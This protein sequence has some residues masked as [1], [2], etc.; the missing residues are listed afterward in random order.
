[1]LLHPW[2]AAP[3][4]ASAATGLAPGAVFGGRHLLRLLYTLPCLLPP[5]RAADGGPP[6]EAQLQH[7][8]RWLH[9]RRAWALDGGPDPK[10]EVDADADADG[11]RGATP[12]ASG[13]RGASETPAASDGGGGGVK[14][15]PAP[16]PPAGG[17]AAAAVAAAMAAGGEGG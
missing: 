16:P 15:E 12:S 11:D 2:E 1:M 6:T 7:F 3:A 17:L 4:A 10:A 9:A 13:G 14:A 5:R 8:V